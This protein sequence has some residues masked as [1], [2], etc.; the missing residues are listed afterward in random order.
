M[1]VN[2]APGKHD[3]GGFPTTCYTKFHESVAS[4]ANQLQFTDLAMYTTFCTKAS[5]WA[6]LG[7]LY[8]VLDEF[9]GYAIFMPAILRG[10]GLQEVTHVLCFRRGSY[11]PMPMYRG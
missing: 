6:A 11:Q 3:R 2:L 1:Q 8:V 10:Y 9:A 7:R 5:R 4:L